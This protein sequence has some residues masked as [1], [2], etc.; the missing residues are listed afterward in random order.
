[1]NVVIL[2]SILLRVVGVG[3]SLVLL[4]QSNDR[5]FG[6]LTVMLSLMA[7]RQILSARHA[8]TALE[9]LPGLLVSVLALLTVYYLSSYV[10]EE[11]RLTDR[12]RGFR[13]AIEHAGHAI[14]LTDTDGTIEYANPAVEKVTGHDPET[15]IGENPRLW[16]SGEHDDE[17]YASMWEQIST[18]NVW[19]GEIINRRKSG[20]LCW[21][22][23]TIAPIT[24]DTGH[25][26]RYVAVERD[27]TDRKERQLRIEDQND[28]LE[29]L[30]NTNEVLRDINRDLVAASTRAEIERVL[31]DRFA[32]SE[33]FET[34]WV[35]EPR[36]ADDRVE[37]QACAGTEETIL[38]ERIAGSGDYRSV[39]E[40]T[41]DSTEPVFIDGETKPVDDPADAAG[42]CVPLSYLDADY[43]VLCVA[44]ATPNSFEAIDQ[45][46]FA[47]L[48]LTVG[49]AI[50]AAES[51]QTL[52]SDDVTQLEFRLDRTADPFVALSETL[53][54]TVEL[55]RVG[56]SDSSDCTVYVSITGADPADISNYVEESSA[57]SEAQVLCS[58]DDCHHIRLRA[59]DSS[60]VT[61]PAQYGAAVTSL[62]VTDGRGR[63][64]ADVSRSN[65]IRSVVDA[66]QS[67]HPELDLVAQR[68][69]E[70]DSDFEARFRSTFEDV[71]T[72]RQLE[73]AQTAYFAGFF[74]WPRDTSGEEVAS[75]MDITQSTFTQHLRSAERKLFQTLFEERLTTAPRPLST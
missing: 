19:D 29:R 64:V 55:D 13:K 59:D 11:Q 58:H 1:M 61:T 73:A 42:V 12:L 30:N 67:V 26:E 32:R 23:M 50:N 22:D 16:K 5:R 57:F 56:S 27:V 8:T 45:E 44:A 28:R 25:V 24:D 18:G 31:C 35:G 6:F 49:D 68:E 39:V 63:L 75:M 41:L 4:S 46:L 38:G 70:R 21:V 74:E 40:D 54:C 2:I 60:V 14:F 9:E 37:V 69:Q 62:A 66:I 20:D 72:D 48:G 47:E 34:A 10:V 65:D 33:L 43:G 52:A 15:V 17:F 53:G 51:R 7:T 36:L 3:Y 71:L